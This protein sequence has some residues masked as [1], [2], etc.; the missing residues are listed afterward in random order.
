MRARRSQPT[1]APRSR[2]LLRVAHRAA[3]LL[4]VRLALFGLLALAACW[5]PLGQAGGMND[6]RDSHMLLSYEEAAA[7]TVAEDGQLPL[8]NPWSCGGMYVWGSPQTR[9]ASPTLLLSAAVGARR[10]EPLL[11]WAFLVLGM[12]GFFRYARGRTGSVLGAL[13][14]APAFGLVGFTALGWTLGWL[15]FAGFL[16]L[17]WLLLGTRLAARGRVG[18]VALVAGGFALLLGFGGTYPVPLGALL[19]TLEAA[20]ELLSPRARG[21]RLAML[22][23][24]SA[25]GLLALGAGAFRLWPLLETMGSAPRVM[26]G[27]PGHVLPELARMVLALPQ[28][29]G[30]GS[31]TWGLFYVG[32]PVLVLAAGAGWGRWR[33]AFP[34]VVAGLALW[35]AAGYAAKPSL[36]AGLRQ[37]PIFETLRY[38][39]R[40]LFPFTLYLTELAALGL[41]VALTWARR[42]SPWRWGAAVACGLVFIGWGLQVHGYEVLSRRAAVVAMPEEV[43]Q[44]F[45]QAR[46]NR[47]AQ[48]HF[49]ALNRGSIACGEAY[50]VPMSAHLR[51]DLP[52]EEFLEEASAGAARR[53]VWTPNRLEVD[54]EA[55]RPAVLR[56]N[57]N[58]HPGWRASVGE[59]VSREGLLGVQ[60]PEG[61]HRVVLRFLPRSGL[62]G[63]AISALAWVGLGWVAWRA[64]RRRMGWEVAVAALVPLLAW[65]ALRALWPEPPAPPVLRNPDGS[66]LQVEALPADARPVGARF[67][68]PVEL[69]AAQ[70]PPGPDA[71]GIVPLVLYW[72]LTGP[73]P[74]SVGIFV[75]LVGP[76]GE[77]K[78]ADHPLLGGT[79]F[80]DDAP[81]GVLLRDAFAVSTRDWPAGEWQVLVGLWHATGNGT[82]LMAQGADGQPMQESRVPVGAFTVPPK[83]P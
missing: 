47:W 26:A 49:L 52:Q 1:V 6:F 10:A 2:R 11:L 45:A 78:G 14:A 79:Y 22:G 38:P 18:G 59:V 72:K 82:R 21:R 44:P 74:R 23:R 50:P 30:E 63:L 53:V 24:L 36:F 27:T 55:A 17:P 51:G 32:V 13:G 29:P 62:G 58:W 75:H 41:G 34:A 5:R 80:F 46:G 16:L 64:R 60:L 76:G 9:V 20:R 65:G 4:S 83:A 61:R 69:V 40:F 19:V 8:W 42:A 73:V 70:V 28:R 15:N 54:V 39:E 33:M 81:H 48:G 66:V 56:V 43:E 71:E 35:L 37:L 77:R 7:R 57:Q 31:G 68:A 67:D 25:T 12:E 3:S